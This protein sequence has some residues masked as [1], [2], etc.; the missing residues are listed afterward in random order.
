MPQHPANVPPEEQHRVRRADLVRALEQ[1]LSARALHL[2]RLHDAYARLMVRR[3][4]TDL[5]YNRWTLAIRIQ[6]AAAGLEALTAKLRRVCPACL[7]YAEW[8]REA[9]GCASHRD[10]MTATAA[11]SGQSVTPFSV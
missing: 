4:P 6:A 10:L 7:A 9:G 1:R 3:T 8:S 2:A 11:R 5:T